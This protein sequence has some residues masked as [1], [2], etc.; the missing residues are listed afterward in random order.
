MRITGNVFLSGRVRG[1][2]TVMVDGSPRIIEPL[3]QVNDPSSPDAAPCADQLG[4]IAVGDILVADNVLLR[5][6]RIAGFP[7]SA[8]FAR[9]LGGSRDIQIH[10]QL[11]SLRGTVGVENPSIVAMSGGAVSCPDGAAANTAGGCFRLVGGAAMLRYS[12]LHAGN[13]T[14]VRWAGLSDR[15]STSGRRPPLFPL[16]SRYTLVRTLEIAPTQANSPTKIRAL[17]M[18]LKGQTL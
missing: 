16:T 13:N 18:R 15:C 6:K 7:S 12:P 2:L 14:G 1:A 8:S 3:T 17:L 9:Q 10:A 5:A 4:L 11:M